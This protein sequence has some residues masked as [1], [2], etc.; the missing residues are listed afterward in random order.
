[1]ALRIKLTSALAK[2][3]GYRGGARSPLLL[4]GIAVLLLV[5]GCTLQTDPNSYE[6]QL[7]NHLS[8][9][10][11]AMYGA[12]WCP[13]C[14]SQKEMFGSA[15]A[16]VPYV[17][18]DPEGQNAQPDL[19]QA[20]NIAGYPTWEIDGQLYPG[21]QSLEDLAQLSEFSASES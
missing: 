17:E 12:Y 2:I 5:A 21:V 13:H 8:E 20:K 4:G 11:A 15:I 9:T 18:C 1:M 10:G 14:E 6:A 3:N 7:A 16:A 19:C